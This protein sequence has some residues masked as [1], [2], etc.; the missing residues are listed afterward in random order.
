LNRADFAYLLR[1]GPSSV[2]V[3]IG[4][5]LGQVSLLLGRHV[6]RVI[7]VEAVAERARLIALRAAQQGLRNV[8]AV[9]SSFHGLNL[10]PASIDCAVLV[11]AF[12]WLPLE[13]EER[14]PGAAQLEALRRIRRWLRPGGQVY[15]GIENRISV[16]SFLGALDHSGLRFTNLMPRKVASSYMS[17]RRPRYRWAHAYTTYRTYTYTARGYRR[18]L[19]EAGFNDVQVYAVLPDYV[20]PALMF[21]LD[22]TA[23]GAFACRS[24]VSSRSLLKVALLRL[25]S[26]RPVWTI[27]RNFVP[28]FG[29][30]GSA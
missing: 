26:Q 18:L 25:A 7:A 22:T 20:R 19:R 30:I 16:K 10:V 3:D 28:Y 14:S 8:E 2:V 9:C 6:G 21:S 24:L 4:S 11:G 29:V 5:G 17:L 27:A 1:L 12:E 13:A 23:T 15:I